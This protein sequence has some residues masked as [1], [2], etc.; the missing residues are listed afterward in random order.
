MKA[1]V[2]TLVVVLVLVLVLALV[3][4]LTWRTADAFDSDQ[5]TLY[6]YPMWGLA[7]RL[8]VVRVA[9]DICLAQ[10]WKLVV[11][12]VPDKGYDSPHLKDLFDVPGI[13]YRDAIP[14]NTPL[15]KFNVEND[16]MIRTSVAEIQQA[17]VRNGRVAIKTCGFK[18]DNKELDGGALMYK[19]MTP[20]PEIL[21][22]CGDALRALRE[23]K[24]TV[25]V[26]I[27]Q[28][29]IPDYQYGQF[30]GNWDSSDKGRLPTACCHQDRAMNTSPCTRHAPVI[31]KFVK[32]MRT[33]PEDAV[34]FVCSDRPGCIDV[35]KKA[36]PG[37]IVTNAWVDTSTNDA[38]GAFCDWWCLSRCKKL[39]CS[40]MSSFSH[41]AKRMSGAKT[42]FVTM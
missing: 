31:E 29:S 41:E 32:I 21:E 33:M 9:Y 17:S 10:G 35:L 39:I 22:A 36:F 18:S 14:P 40:G 27:R 24:N 13:E 20:R 7:N 1:V 37:R 38:F 28:G 42:T 12:H 16:C 30:F 5:T 11:V 19:K 6:V 34:F 25:G 23:T 2:I 4:G 15:L 3:L 8:R 26:H